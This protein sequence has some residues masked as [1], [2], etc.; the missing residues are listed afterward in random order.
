MFIICPLS[1]ALLLLR[2]LDLLLN[3]G[4]ILIFGFIQVYNFASLLVDVFI[5]VNKL[6]IH[7]CI[8]ILA[9]EHRYYLGT[10]YWTAT[11]FAG[12]NW[13]SSQTS[14]NIYRGRISP[15]L[16]AKLCRTAHVSM[17]L[18]ARWRLYLISAQKNLYNI[19]TYIIRMTTTIKAK[20]Y[21]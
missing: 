20:L 8:V 16:M 14:S 11:L 17:T 4:D 21:N 9:C 10:S 6:V 3:I 7:L 1:S 13:G 15:H 18:M 5:F 2:L 12:I 19:N